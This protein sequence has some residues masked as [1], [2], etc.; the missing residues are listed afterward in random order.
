MHLNLDT[1]D[2]V[3]ATVPYDEVIKLVDNPPGSLHIWI[4]NYEIPN[5][6]VTTLDVIVGYYQYGI[7]TPHKSFTI[8]EEQAKFILIEAMLDG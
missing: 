2:V 3:L 1:A 7:F 6:L 8:T 5:E 4:Y